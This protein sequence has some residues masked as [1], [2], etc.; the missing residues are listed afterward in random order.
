[1]YVRFF[2][3]IID[4]VLSLI[5]TIILLP[6]FLVVSIAILIDDPGPVFFKQK[7]FGKDKKF[8]NIYKFR[9]MKVDTPNVA[10]HLLENPDL[11][12]TRVGKIL[13]KTSLDEVPQLINILFN[14]MSIVGPR[15]GLYTQDDLI[16][17]RDANGS[18][19]V[20]PGLTGWAQ[21]NGRDEITME[22]KVRLDGEYVEKMSFLFDMKCVIGTVKAV[23]KEEGIA[24]GKQPEKSHKEEQE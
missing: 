13:R 20:K 15:P 3:R 10:T 19:K 7:R 1:M 22:E 5:A 12:I 14:H 18:N 6:V 2:K 16:A 17:M 4:F 9:T 11:Y 23:F 8:F 24:E 21:I